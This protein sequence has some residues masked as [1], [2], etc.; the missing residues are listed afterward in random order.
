M[1]HHERKKMDRNNQR[2]Q[3]IPREV[4]GLL[5][6]KETSGNGPFLLWDISET[7]FGIWSATQL[8]SNQ[9]VKLLIA[10]PF[11]L[12]VE[13]T[14]MWVEKDAQDEGYRAGL[15]LLAGFAIPQNILEQFIDANKAG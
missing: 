12:T 5:Q 6:V 3:V 9:T 11:K 1:A 8:T 2:A 7:G 13:C 10:V 14:V 15:K 4:R